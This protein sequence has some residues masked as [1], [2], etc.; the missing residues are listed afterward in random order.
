MDGGPLDG[1]RSSYF[2]AIKA[3]FDLTYYDVLTFSFF[4]Q[5]QQ[6]YLLPV[7]ENK[8]KPLNDQIEKLIGVW[9]KGKK[10]P[11]D[12]LAYFLAKFSEDTSQSL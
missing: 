11:V 8:H 1:S 2:N 9:Y 4:R 6:D 7:F 10:D 12:I 5:E 3:D